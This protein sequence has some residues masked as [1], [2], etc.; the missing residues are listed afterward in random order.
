MLLKKIMIFILLGLGSLFFANFFIPNVE[1]IKSTQTI[2][3]EDTN[4]IKI[5]ETEPEPTPLHTQDYTLYIK[6]SF[7]QYGLIK[8]QKSNNSNYYG[9]MNK[10][11]RLVIDCI[12][13]EVGEFHEGIV[14]VFNNGW[15]FVDVDGKMITALEYDSVKPFR[16]SYAWVNKGTG[17][18]I[19]KYGEI[20]DSKGYDVLDEYN[21]GLIPVEKYDVFGY[22]DID[23]NMILTL[24]YDNI[25]RMN[26]FNDGYAT[27]ELKDSLVGIDKSGN[28]IFRY[29]KEQKGKDL[30]P[31]K[32]Y[33]PFSISIGISSF[34]NYHASIFGITDANHITTNYTS[35]LVS[36]NGEYVASGSYSYPL[37]KDL[38]LDLKDSSYYAD[39]EILNLDTG[40][41]MPVTLELPYLKN[42][43]VHI[44]GEELF[45]S[46]NGERYGYVN[47]EGKLIFN[48]I[49]EDAKAFRENM[50]PVKMNGKW[51]YI[52]KELRLLVDYKYDEAWL[53]SEGVAVATKGYEVD[54]NYE[55]EIIQ[56]PLL[57]YKSIII[58]F[59][60]KFSKV[61]TIF[62]NNRAYLPLSQLKKYFKFESTYN[63]IDNTIFFSND[64]G[65]TFLGN[66][67]NTYYETE[68]YKKVS[69]VPILK[70]SDE[71]FLPISLLK[72]F[73]QI[74][75][76]FENEILTIK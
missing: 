24:P 16:N 21:E 75:V 10:R 67:G 62:L 39:D 43:G 30:V 58:H 36:T 32:K 52:D 41:K 40:F 53:F 54:E 38:V 49:F 31:N 15:G 28:E 47:S 66:I 73:F 48:Y 61:D 2:S 6:E 42:T 14:A 22:V 26:S 18:L 34:A 69:D 8:V 4:Y 23:F 60:K 45:V 74:E 35:F 13:W 37:R 51:G 3:N 72:D 29:Y 1:L 71:I 63:S 7:F 9:F 25:E 19:N 64:K 55:Y 65:K 68:S 27:L 50:A 70:Y 5:T 17:F 56:N 33:L 12:Y 46:Y 76:S 44:F 11:G 57:H 59:D 20:L